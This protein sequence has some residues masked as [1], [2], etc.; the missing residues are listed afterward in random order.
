MIENFLF[1]DPYVYIS[2]LS[3]GEKRR[4]YLL[5]ILMTSPNVLL[6]D[7]PTN[8]LD[9][10]TLNILEDYIENFDGIVIIVSHDRYFLDKTVNCVV[11]FLQ[12]EIQ[13]FKQ[14]FFS[15]SFFLI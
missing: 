2:K 1:D 6:F 9:I 13:E 11:S 7:E 12:I 10:E 5:S 14:F 15:K 8:D 4:L 3:G